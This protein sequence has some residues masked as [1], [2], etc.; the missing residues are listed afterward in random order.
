MYVW[1][2][3]VSLN[4]ELMS[5]YFKYF[6]DYIFVFI[7]ICRTEM[8]HDVTLG[9]SFSGGFRLLTYVQN[10][11]TNKRRR[12]SSSFPEPAQ[13]VPPVLVNLWKPLQ[14]LNKV[15]QISQI[16]NTSLTNL[17]VIKLFRSCSRKQEEPATFHLDPGWS[18]G[19]WMYEFNQLNHIS[20]FVCTTPH[21]DVTE[22]RSFR[23]NVRHASPWRWSCVA[24][25]LV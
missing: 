20:F 14:D 17:S 21:R 4:V 11:Q 16:F 18:T 13:T 5:G 7:R 9:N 2:L 24:D 25:T 8:Q 3:T 6:S 19:L 22:T 10:L 1:I 23:S 15:T 12:T